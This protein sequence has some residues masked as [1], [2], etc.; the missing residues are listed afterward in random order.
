MRAISG[1]IRLVFFPAL[2]LTLCVSAEALTGDPDVIHFSDGTSRDDGVVM[3]EEA[4]VL[5][6]QEFGKRYHIEIFQNTV[7]SVRYHDYPDD[8]RVAVGCLRKRDY[9]RAYAHFEKTLKNYNPEEQRTWVP[10]YALYQMARCLELQGLL[11]GDAA[12]VES[13]AKTYKRLR[14]DYEKGKF[15]LV[16][17]HRSG[18]CYADAAALASSREEAQKMRE[19]ARQSYGALEKSAPELLK[20]EQM[21]NDRRDW[22]ARARA[23]KLALRLHDGTISDYQT[24][25][26]QFELDAKEIGV[27]SPVYFEV[28]ARRVQCEFAMARLKDEGRETAE[29]MARKLIEE[30]TAS[31][32]IDEHDSAQLIV[33]MYA[34][35]ADT[36][37]E[38]ARGLPKKAPRRAHL[39]R[40]CLGAYLRIPL[41]YSAEEDAAAEHARALLLGARAFILLGDRPAA[42]KLLITLKSRFG[43]SEVWKKKAEEMLEEIP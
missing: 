25:A 2:A 28:R 38:R 36:C 31:T 1:I 33:R 34:L 26:R 9:A 3:E 13:A 16:A 24:L 20:R 8:Y 15:A 40:S 19:A 7:K 27:E 43:K 39:L 11:D 32:V 29:R 10:Q 18:R 37:F 12:K 5:R 23:G 6:Y 4:G 30:I 17:L 22:A 35:I 14:N 21:K 42:G 41:L